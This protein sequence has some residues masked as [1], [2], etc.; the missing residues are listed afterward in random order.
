MARRRAQRARKKPRSSARRRRRSRAGR[1]VRIR[2]RRGKTV[3]KV[4]H[5]VGRTNPEVDR[6]FEALPP[7]KRISASGKEYWETRK[8]R[9]DLRGYV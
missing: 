6:R 7:G 9:S 3:K 5:Q 2:K 4:S 8:N 1:P